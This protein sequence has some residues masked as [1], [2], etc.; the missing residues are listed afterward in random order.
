M[1]KYLFMLITIILPF[2]LLAQDDKV[3]TGNKKNKP[4]VDSP[5]GG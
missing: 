5:A 3:I 4:E 1:K 2:V